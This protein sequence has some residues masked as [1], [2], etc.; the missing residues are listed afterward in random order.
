MEERTTTTICSC[1][2]AEGRKL[3]VARELG[4]GVYTEGTRLHA[5][6]I[7]ARRLG[8]VGLIDESM[9]VLHS[10]PPPPQRT[11]SRSSLKEGREGIFFC[12]K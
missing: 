9:N 5:N 1:D 10:A 11:N 2:F 8:L 4:E 6:F 12:V 3:G 7:A